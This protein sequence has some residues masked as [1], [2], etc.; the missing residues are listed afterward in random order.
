MPSNP[1]AFCLLCNSPSSPTA[2][3][4]IHAMMRCSR[5][6]FVFAADRVIPDGL[7]DTAYTADGEY[8]GLMKTAKA[9]RD[10]VAGFD[11]MHQWVFDHTSPAGAR[12]SL[13][14]G[15][16]VGSAAHLASRAGWTA[17]GQDV[18]ENALK[19][20]G[21]IFGIATFAQPISSLA[22]QG[23]KF[24]LVTAF[25]LLEHIPD[26]MSYLR[27]VRSITA[28]NG[29]FAVA[30]P[31]YDSY[32]MRNTTWDQWLPPFHLN[33]FTLKTLGTALEATGF[34]LEVHIIKFASWSGVEG[35]KLRRVSLIPYLAANALI[36]RLRGNGIVA[37]AR[38]V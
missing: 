17:F 18:S 5:C 8:R 15:C 38:A 14:L 22:E 24:D 11:W 12:R 35:S 25:N 6:C 28:D 33:F 2:P 4:H 36:G 26:P 19:V 13:D 1:A 16:G 10:G 9:Q 21:E 32:A 3:I 7:Y 34:K 23:E 20:A 29:R 31:N 37:V 27:T 30:V